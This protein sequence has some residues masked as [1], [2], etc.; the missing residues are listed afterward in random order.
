[1]DYVLI[2]VNSLS[3]II[4]K[5][6]DEFQN[7]SKQVYFK[8]ERFSLKSEVVDNVQAVQRLPSVPKKITTI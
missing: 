6:S 3:F 1:M 4:V 7:K 5:V 2:T 8:P